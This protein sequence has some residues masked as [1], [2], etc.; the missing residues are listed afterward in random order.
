M[1]AFFR[2]SLDWYHKENG[3]GNCSIQLIDDGIYKGYIVGKQ[4]D[5]WGI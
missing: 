3:P 1:K 4:S 5:E 2:K